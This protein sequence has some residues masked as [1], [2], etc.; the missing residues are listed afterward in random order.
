MASKIDRAY[1]TGQDR[2]GRAMNL[3]SGEGTLADIVA[4]AGETIRG[5]PDA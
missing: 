2:T 3:H 4:F 5:L 1:G